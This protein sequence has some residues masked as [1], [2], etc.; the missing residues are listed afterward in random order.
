MTMKVQVS[1]SP[2]PKKKYQAIIRSK[3]DDVLKIVHFGDKRFEDFTKH[4]D[5]KRKASYLARHEPGQDWS[6]NGLDT[7]G[8]WSRWF[9]WNKPTLRK[10]IRDLNRR[11]HKQIKVYF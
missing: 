5:E 1:P 2:K 10:S 8:F 11:F 7:A 6:I 3:D 4:G 9:L